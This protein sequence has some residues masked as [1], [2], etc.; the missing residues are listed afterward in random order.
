MSLDAVRVHARSQPFPDVDCIRRKRNSALL[1]RTLWRPLRT[2]HRTRCGQR[3]LVFD[4][5]EM[6]CRE[7]CNESCPLLCLPR[8]AI[9]SS[10][11]GDVVGV[12]LRL[13][14]IATT[15]MHTIPS[16]PA[17]KPASAAAPNLNA[18]LRPPRSFSLPPPPSPSP[19]LAAI[20]LPTKAPLSNSKSK[21]NTDVPEPRVATSP[22]STVA[23]TPPTAI[24]P[25]LPRYPLVPHQLVAPAVAVINILQTLYPDAAFPIRSTT[26]NIWAN[27]GWG[28]YNAH[29][30]EVLANV[31]FGFLKKV[32]KMK[33]CGTERT[34]GLSDAALEIV[35]EALVD[36]EVIT[37]LFNSQPQP[38]AILTSQ[39]G[40][41]RWFVQPPKNF[42]RLFA[43]Y[44]GA[45]VRREK[46]DE[47]K[48]K[49]KGGKMEAELAE[50]FEMLA[51]MLAFHCFPVKCG[52]VKNG[53]DPVKVSESEPDVLEKELVEA[54]EKE[55]KENVT[56]CKR[57][58]QE[59]ADDRTVK[60]RATTIEGWRRHVPRTRY[61]GGTGRQ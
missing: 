22:D 59:L 13:L 57:A 14:S 4:I 56:P 5:L 40:L 51:P 25:T 27:P 11:V 32:I 17:S 46:F 49:I 43:I 28:V 53:N 54:L 38:S 61:A 60:R 34:S 44:V 47:R 50:L 29:W 30:D 16:T 33:A 10:A 58:A 18:P 1:G 8:P 52:Y 35:A 6:G 39:L 2:R 55:E 21:N 15:A 7:T 36:E 41:T 48:T 42:A 23:Q 20:L 24:P 31:G 19:S 26:T 12:A 37:A 45:R 9:G 3:P